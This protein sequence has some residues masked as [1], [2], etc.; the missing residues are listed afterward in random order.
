MIVV[1]DTSPVANL[2]AVGQLDLLKALYGEVVIPQSV[3]QE[4][5][6]IEAFGV[7]VEKFIDAGWIRIEVPE[8]HA[9]VLYFKTLLDEGEAE[10]IALALELKADRLLIDE[11]MG[12][13]VALDAGLTTTGLLGVLLEAKTKGH[14]SL[15]KPVLDKLIKVGF[16][17]SKPLY[18]KV[19]ATAGE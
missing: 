9:K 14:L 12:H 16:W 11:R 15:V 13:R 5:S 3:F 10:A 6:D 8:D 19:L 18:E 17:M 7:P 2:L 1:S 4:V